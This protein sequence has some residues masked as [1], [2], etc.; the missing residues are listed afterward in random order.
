[1]MG[2]MTHTRLEDG[3]PMVFRYSRGSFFGGM[4][5]YTIQREGD[6]YA[7]SVFGMNGDFIEESNVISKQSVIDMVAK[8]LVGL[9]WFE[10]YTDYSITDGYTWSIELKLDEYDFLSWGYVKTPP[11]YEDVTA[12]LEDALCYLIAFGDDYEGKKRLDK[13]HIWP[14][15]VIKRE[16][17]AIGIDWDTLGDDE[18]EEEKHQEGGFE[19][20]EKQARKMDPLTRRLGTP[21]NPYNGPKCPQCGQL[22]DHLTP[23]CL[24][25]GLRISSFLRHA[26]FEEVQRRKKA[27][28]QKD[29]VASDFPPEC[30]VTCFDEILP[31]DTVVIKQSTLDE[32]KR[33]FNREFPQK[34][35]V[36][37]TES[38]RPKY[39]GEDSPL[40]E[41]AG[42]AGPESELITFCRWNVESVI[43]IEVIPRRAESDSSDEH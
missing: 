39:E 2:K 43:P 14:L 17:A 22:V 9:Y 31:G 20:N 13:L 1:M 28:E 12:P 21:E 11:D 24:N 35:V 32:A 42:T 34:L 36:I 33:Q 6:K 41:F 8:R 10:E 37:Y 4:R 26:V 15:E 25:C 3:S 27:F 38:Q 16:L 18:T 40:E 19:Q 7:I 23:F 5:E 29:E 30:E